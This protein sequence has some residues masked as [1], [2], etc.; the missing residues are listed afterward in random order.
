MKRYGELKLLGNI[1]NVESLCEFP[2]TKADGINWAETREKLS[3]GICNASV[4]ESHF[5]GRNDIC[6]LSSQRSYYNDTVLLSYFESELLIMPHSF[7]SRTPS[8]D[9]IAINYISLSRSRSKQVQFSVPQN[10]GPW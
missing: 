1:N 6:Y 5:L 4:K 10:N 7:C 2:E 9:V 3:I 8:R